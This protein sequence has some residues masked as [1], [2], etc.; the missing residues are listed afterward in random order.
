M[1]SLNS[2]GNDMVFASIMYNQSISILNVLKETFNGNLED[3][4]AIK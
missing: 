1:K 4:K 2:F 3:V